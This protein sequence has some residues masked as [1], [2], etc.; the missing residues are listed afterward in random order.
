MVLCRNGMHPKY[1]LLLHEIQVGNESINSILELKMI[2]IFPIKFESYKTTT[3]YTG[4]E[5]L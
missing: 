4:T 5:E 1:I 3:K 2:F